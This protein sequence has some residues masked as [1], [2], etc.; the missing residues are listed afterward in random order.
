MIPAREHTE[1]RLLQ[2][3]GRETLCNEAGIF[4]ETCLSRGRV[5]ISGVKSRGTSSGVSIAQAEA[6]L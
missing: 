5:V 4:P 6:G 2:A 1:G 3:L